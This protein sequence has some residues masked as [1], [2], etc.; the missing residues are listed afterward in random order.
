MNHAAPQQTIEIALDSA[1]IRLLMIAAEQA[2]SQPKL[3]HAIDVTSLAGQE[4]W[5]HAIALDA[6][7]WQG[8][9]DP[10][11]A[12]IATLQNLLD[13]KPVSA[14]LIAALSTT[15]LA[16]L[17]AY[18]R[19]SE[20]WPHLAAD[21]RDKLLN[22]TAAGWIEQAT[23]REIPFTPEPT[24]EAAILAGDRLD[25]AL[26]TIATS[27]TRA[28]F[29][30]VSA[31]PLFDEHRFLRWLNEPSMARHQ[32]SPADAETLGRLVLNR[33]WRHVID[34]LVDFARAGRTDLRPALRICHEMVGVFTRWSLNLS[35]V[36]FDEK[37]VVFEE[38]AVDLYP[39]GP[40]DNELWDRAGGKNWDLQTFG[41]GRSRW[42]D[43]ITQI[44]RGKGPRSSRLLSEMRRDFPLNDQVR[45]LANDSDLGGY[46]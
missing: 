22:A 1:D 28:V 34:S 38:L 25:R 2:A 46:R 20:V 43:A 13:G 33:R 37:W 16:D 31:L 30:I 23:T 9:S 40:D 39:T 6:K 3:L 12:L 26:R 24:L 32:L 29:S 5:A 36:T 35:A 17:T 27:G 11:G 45:Y 18:P 44:R 10:Q 42:H 14:K 15:P 19:R 8:P 7:A 41:S 4:L 21:V